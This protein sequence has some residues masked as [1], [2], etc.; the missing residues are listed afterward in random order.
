MRWLTQL[1]RDRLELALLSSTL[2][3]NIMANEQRVSGVPYKVELPGKVTIITCPMCSYSMTND[4][5]NCPNCN[6]RFERFTRPTR[7]QYFI[8]MVKVVATRGACVRRKTGCIL[9]NKHNH[10][11]ATGYNGK[12]AGLANCLDSPCSG[13]CADSGTKLDECEAIHAEANAL[14]QCNDT[15]AIHTAYCT[16][17]PCIHCVKMLL[18][19][20]V[21][22]I[23]FIDDYPHEIS[24][25]L[26]KEAG[27]KWE[28]FS[29]ETC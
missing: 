29:E 26:C 19:T 23:V 2:M 4:H 8:D 15:Q 10:V 5:R 27:V 13:A 24:E 22:R 12:P 28:Q 11:I 1:Y 17:A 18:N 16:T 25:R 3:V 14:I 20:S 21:Q 6:H 7:D 9:V